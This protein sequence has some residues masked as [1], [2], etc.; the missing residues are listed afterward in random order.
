MSALERPKRI[1]VVTTPRPEATKL[2]ARTYLSKPFAF[3]HLLEQLE[4]LIETPAR[5]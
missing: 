1:L 5:V 3:E 2:G 4:A